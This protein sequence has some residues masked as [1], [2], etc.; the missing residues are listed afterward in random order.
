MISEFEGSL[1]YRV[2]SRTGPPGLYRETLSG[3]TKT[4]KQTQNTK[5]KKTRKTNKQ[6][7]RKR[8]YL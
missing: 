4:N 5:H 6:T 8:K 7:N 2:S 3:K 1:V